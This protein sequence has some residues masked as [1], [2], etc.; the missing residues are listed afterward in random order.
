MRAFELLRVVD[1][2]GISGTGLVA[3]GVEFSDGVVALRWLESAT[4]RPDSGVRPTT[5][6]HESIDSVVALHGH[7]M[8]TFVRFVG[9]GERLYQKEGN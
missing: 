9:T 6:I 4:A 3:E 8:S 1:P 2:T 7:G 5:V